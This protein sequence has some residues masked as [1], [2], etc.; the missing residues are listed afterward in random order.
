[1]GGM[2]NSNALIRIAESRELE[3]NWTQGFEHF[4]R[5]EVVCFDGSGWSDLKILEPHQ[6]AGLKLAIF[7]VFVNRNL[8]SLYSRVSRLLDLFHHYLS[9]LFDLSQI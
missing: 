9:V 5:A 8:P 4:E 1:M 7:A 6:H 3:N 2:S